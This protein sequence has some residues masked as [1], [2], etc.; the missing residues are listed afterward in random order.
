MRILHITN[1][2]QKIGNGIVNVA[3]D[4]ACLQA[5]SGLDVAV[6]SAGGEYEKLLTDHGIE[7]FYLN[8]C[9]T[10]LNLIKAVGHYRRIIKEFQP[11]IVHVHMMTGAILAGI[12]RKNRE[13]HLVSTVHNEFQHSAIL[14]GL[15]DQV[16]AVSKAV[17]N[18]MIQRGIPS[19]KLRVVSNG[20][21]GSPRHK[22]LQ[23]Y[24]PVAMQHPS[25]TTV[26]GMYT[27]KGIYELIEAFK[28]VSID[29][30]QAHLYLVGDGPDRP[31]FEAMVQ[32][33]GLSNRI[34]FEGFQA[35]PQCYMLATDIFVLASH[36][37]SFG[38]VLTEAREAGC[39]II[40]SDVDGIPETLD[41]S[42]AGILVPPKDISTLAKTLTQ[43]LSDRQLL[44]QWKVRAQQNLERFSAARVHE[45][46]LTI[47]RE[48]I[49]KDNI[50]RVIET[51]ELANLN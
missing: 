47:Y 16:I 10:P 20:T 25:I 7:H 48:L 41:Y 34:H 14:M 38:L 22:K 4:L 39:A 44:D 51:R 2:V 3:V 37:E 8:Q 26:A 42:Q 49:R 23:D 1:H 35:E 11:D 33:T 18:S 17:A 19:Q 46:T 45:E 40:A 50:I 15:A 43:L 9:R 28:I 32:N 36:C 13:Y 29:F 31:M 6:A 30:P 12:W 27:R 5:K 21:L 24:Q